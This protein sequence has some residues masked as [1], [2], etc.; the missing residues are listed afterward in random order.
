MDNL[1]VIRSIMNNKEI[2]KVIAKVRKT[3]QTNMFSKTNVVKIA[4]SLGYP[5]IADS[6][7]NMD[8]KEY[9]DILQ[10]SA[11]Y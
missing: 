8:N 11:N 5:D 2:A 10:E 7:H 9:M 1:T 4:D 3:G 6:I